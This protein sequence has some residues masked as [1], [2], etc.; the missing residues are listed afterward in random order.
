MIR[1]YLKRRRNR[2]TSAE[3]SLTPLIDTALTL[4]IIFMIATPMMH[5]SIK[6]NLP[7]GKARES[8][9][10][11]EELVVSLSENGA[12]FFNGLPVSAENLVP[13]VQHAVKSQKIE[14]PVFVRADSSVHY[15]KVIQVVDQLKMVGGIEYVALATKKA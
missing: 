12:I 1:P 4:L 11:Q 6:I 14:K 2:T 3:I 9:A 5:N 13:T 10:S 7:E 15:G 8:G